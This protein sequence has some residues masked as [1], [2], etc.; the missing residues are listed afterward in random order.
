[1]ALM[2]T[3]Q[4]ASIPA[5]FAHQ[6]PDEHWHAL[7]DGGGSAA[8]ASLWWT[9]TPPL[10][11]ERVGVIGHWSAE[12]ADAAHALL[13]HAA[14]RLAAGGCT[15]AVGPMDGNTWARHR[16]VTQRGGEAPFLMEP[17]NPDDW[18]GHWRDAG[19][20]PLAQY[21]SALVTDLAHEDAQ[22]ARA[23]KRLRDCGVTLRSLRV[24]EFDEELRRI[25]EVSRHAFADNFLYT[26]IPD[27]EFI[28]QYAAVRERVR[29]DLVLL[30]ERR[31]E[32]VG[33]SFSIPDWL[34]GPAPDTIIEKTLAVLPGR[35][36][37]GL[38]AWLLMETQQRA[39]AL[40][41]RRGIHALMHESNNSLNL[42]RR[43]GEPF[44]RY[45]LFSRRL[46]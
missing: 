7:D 25:F 5:A 17:Q 32:V 18:P 8:R 23:A 39:H 4:K 3:F 37:A 13:I 14:A 29:P 16:L 15:L 19:F 24:D 45:T 44:R 28:A 1:M 35:E 26:P 10:P 11:G 6:A 41:F 42:S 46:K 27:P 30:A 31:G 38:G 20:V 22:I 12:S 2:F 9:S 34:R 40:G 36:F 33:F 21:F 43:F